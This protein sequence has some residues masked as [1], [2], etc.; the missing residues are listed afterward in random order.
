MKAGLVGPL[1]EQGFIE[2]AGR[3]LIERIGNQ[4]KRGQPPEEMLER[5]LD[6][7]R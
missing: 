5:L 4:L 3:Q 7:F 6:Y 2:A 1:E